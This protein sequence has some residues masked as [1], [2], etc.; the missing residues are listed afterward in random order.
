MGPQ[1]W[2]GAPTGLGSAGSPW[3]VPVQG[4]G[5][6]GAAGAPVPRGTPS[7]APLPAA[8]PWSCTSTS[9]RTVASGGTWVIPATTPAPRARLWS[10]PWQR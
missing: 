7:P 4:S 9:A 10:S 1:A 3:V 5:A 8:L 6:G 2:V